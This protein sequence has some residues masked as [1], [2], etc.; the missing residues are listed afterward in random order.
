LLVI[1]LKTTA[2]LER[3]FEKKASDYPLVIAIV[4]RSC[5]PWYWAI[6]IITV[7]FLIFLILAAYLDGLFLDLSKWNLWRDY[8]DGPILTIYILM[9]YPFVWQWWR[10]AVQAVQQLL[11]E[12]Q[13]E[14]SQV[15]TE[16]ATKRHWEWVAMLVGIILWVSLQQPWGWTWWPNRPWLSIYDI[17]T[18]IILF[19]VL[20]WLVYSS[21]A[22]SQHL[23]RL[24]RKQLNLD[25]FNPGLLTPIARSSLSVSFSFIGGISLSMVFQTQESFLRWNNIIIYAV[26]VCVTVLLFFLSMWSIHSTMV[27]N[28]NRKLELAKKHLSEAS[29]KLEEKTLQGQL[30]GLDKLSA[31]ISA[32]GNYDRLIKEAPVW[33]FNAGIIRRLVA[34]TVVPFVV[35]LIRVLIGRRLGL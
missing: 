33:P 5:L 11:L 24:S 28:R 31:T 17:V 3:L 26:L 9:V 16:S 10:Q 19:G 35:Y 20:G 21:L 7:V 1:S 18:Q 27:K 14:F 2:I 4:R 32:W 25:I 30:E 15:T 34:S 29:H 12:D 22:G 6:A 13:G 8:L 23:S